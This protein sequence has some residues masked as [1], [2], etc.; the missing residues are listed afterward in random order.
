MLKTLFSLIFI[1]GSAS[2]YAA[3]PACTVNA[4]G[5][6]TNNIVAGGNNCYVTPDF[7]YL[8]VYKVG[9]C[10]TTPTYNNYLTE[11]SFLYDSSTATE[12]EVVKGQASKLVGDITLTEGSYQASVLLL[13]TTIAYKHTQT[14]STAQTGS[15][16]SNNDTTGTTCVS[17]TA[18]GNEDDLTSSGGNIDGFYECGNNTLIAGKFTESSGAYDDTTTTCQIN[19][20]VVERSTNSG[21]LEFTTSSGS[22]VMCG[23]SDASTL[24]AFSNGNS[25]KTK[26]LAI[27]TF[28]NP[29]KIS[30]TT[31][32]LEIGLKVT[33]MLGL[34]NHGGYYNA[35]LDGV[36]LK[37]TAQ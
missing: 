30:P 20:G 24:E 18:S 34:E 31:T 5:E 27:Q 6:V 17:R 26:V 9:I 37:V 8:P 29:V 33:D 21:N 2:V 15:N 23:M 32:S 16:S 4:D 10:S 12:V 22:T 28:T 35:F 14:F 11:C 1:F 7:A 25:N 13:G 19:N 36:E 3:T